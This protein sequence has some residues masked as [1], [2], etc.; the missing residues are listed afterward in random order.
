MQSSQKLALALTLVLIWCLAQSA[1]ESRRRWRKSVH[2]K[3]HREANHTKI[4]KSFHNQK[5]RLKEKLSPTTDVAISSLTASLASVAKDNLFNSHNTEYY[6]TASFGTPEAQKVTLLVDTASANLLV[7]TSEFVSESCTQHNGYSSSESQTYQANGSPF[8]IQFASQDVLKGFLSTDTFTL[9]DLAVRNQT[10]AEINSAPVNLCKRSNFDGILGLGLSQIALDGVKTPLDNILE[11]GL[12][13]EP[14]FSL[15]VN[16]NASDAS[17]GGV[18]LL[19]GADPTLYSG[20][21][22]YVPL[23][24][25]GFWQITVGQVAIGSKKLCSNC[26]AIFDMGTSLIIVPCPAL[27]IIN[28]KLGIKEA[29]KK[30]GVYIIDCSKVSRLP[31]VVLNIGW[32]DFTL[33]PSDYVLNYSGTCVSGF[34]SLSACNGSG[35]PI[36]DDGDDLNNIWVFGDVFFGAIFT[37]FD[38]GLK[39]VGMAPKV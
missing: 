29:D 27:K 9:G 13:D 34:S 10:F 39:L 16:R 15:Y 5:L 38:F 2:L 23:S 1:V 11:Q 17:N 12:I 20:C 26:Q 4:L 31:N 30:D 28:R 35:T 32:K 14:I 18:L 19:G 7:Y 37:L 22:T 3:L 36:N 25:V 33:T 6:V 24:K 8:E 21:L